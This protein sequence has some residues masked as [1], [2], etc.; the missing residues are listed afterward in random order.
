MSDEPIPAL[1]HETPPS[2]P[3]PA[4]AL[5]AAMEHGQSLMDVFN[6]LNDSALGIES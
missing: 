2:V 3:D 1:P 5:Q 6:Q 4:T